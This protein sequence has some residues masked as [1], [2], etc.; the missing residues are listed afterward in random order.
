MTE[1]SWVSPVDLVEHK[2]KVPQHRSNPV[3]QPFLISATNPSSENE[4]SFLTQSDDGDT[5]TTLGASPFSSTSGDKDRLSFGFSL[6]S[7]NHQSSRA[8]AW[9]P[10]PSPISEYA[11]PSS[12]IDGDYV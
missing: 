12:E 4:N 9:S 7:S 1:K 6:H 10:P 8:M 11:R 2:S 5:I 3:G